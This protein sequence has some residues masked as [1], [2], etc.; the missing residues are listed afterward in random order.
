MIAFGLDAREIVEAV[1]QDG[2]LRLEYS[3]DDVYLAYHAARILDK[4]SG[5]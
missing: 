3:R 1:Q 5:K 2:G 4:Y